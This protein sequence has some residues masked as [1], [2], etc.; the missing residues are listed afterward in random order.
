MAVM[1]EDPVLADQL[2][3]R[4]GNNMDKG[5]WTQRNFDS[6]KESA[7]GMAPPANW[8]RSVR[9]AEKAKLCAPGGISLQQRDEFQVGSDPPGMSRDSNRCGFVQAG[10]QWRG[11]GMTSE[12]T[13]V[14]LCLFKK[15]AES[16][17][18]KATPF[19]LLRGHLTGWRSRSTL[20][21]ISSRPHR[22]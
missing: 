19:R 5:V 20:R 6:S 3:Y 10:D 16:L 14:G 17:S 7:S 11:K 13:P 12:P 2:F 1:V 22:R 18:A 9:E 8:K 15:Y 4:I 21:V